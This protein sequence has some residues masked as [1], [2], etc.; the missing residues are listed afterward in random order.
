MGNLIFKTAIVFAVAIVTACQ[1]I[2]LEQ[3]TE[4]AE[5][6]LET[7]GEGQD[8]FYYYFDEKVFLKER[9]DMLFIRFEDNV[10]RE[11]FL[12]DLNNLSIIKPWDADG[13]KS[14][15]KGNAFNMLVVQTHS[16]EPIPID[17]FREIN[18]RKGVRVASFL[19]ENNGEL[20]APTDEF[21]VRLR[22][23]SDITRLEKLVERFGCE[24]SHREWFDPEVFFVRCKSC[25]ENSMIHIANFFYETG[26]FEYTSPDFILFNATQS[27]DPYYTDQWNMYNTGPY[28]ASGIDIKVSPAWYYTEGSDDIVVA[29]IDVGVD[30]I[31][32]DLATNMVTGY[33][34]I[35][36]TVGG[37]PA[38]DAANHGTP[39][40]GIIA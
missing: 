19:T 27:S 38:S 11:G 20:A 21:I 9:K 34:A 35:N 29:V 14:Y 4:E 23:L 8:L 40:A 16:G 5:Y 12:A 7:K 22:R 33:D 26:L 17:L 15:V 24:M 18:N 39:V 36:N 6:T 32:P 31:H 25:V 37:S 1:R 13:Q 10:S 3:N 28:G 2:G 30:L